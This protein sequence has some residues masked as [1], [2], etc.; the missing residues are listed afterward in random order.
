M[1]YARSSSQ[2]QQVVIVLAVIAGVLQVALA[3]QI[4]LFGGRFNF[5]LAF[6][7]AT[8]LKGDSPQAVF[9]GFFAGL[10][11]DLTA[12]VPVGLMTL[13]TL[14]ASFVLA[15]IGGAGTSGFSSTSMRL[16]G[17]AALAVCL[18]NGIALV[19]LG[20]EGSLLFSFGHAIMTAVLTTIATI[21][22]LM[23]SSSAPSLGGGGM[24]RPLHSGTRFKSSAPKRRRYR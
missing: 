21:P 23:A 8:A 19:I 2:S 17:A 7:L 16:A 5:M 22:F 10:F 24:S 12:S 15:G 4:S 11:Y 20:V 18:L 9:A 6:A 1:P 3:P 13:L 14:V